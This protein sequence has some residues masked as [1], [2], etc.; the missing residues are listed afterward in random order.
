MLLSRQTWRAVVPLAVAGIVLLA[1]SLVIAIRDVRFARAEAESELVALAEAASAAVV[2]LA[3][4]HLHEYTGNLL[5]HPAVGMV[6]VYSEDRGQTA[7]SREPGDTAPPVVD[8]WIARIVPALREPLV[9]CRATAGIT[10]CVESDMSHYRARVAALIVPHAVLLGATTLLLLVTTILA[11]GSSRNDVRAITTVLQSASDASNYALRAPET[12]GEVAELARAANKLLEQMQ[13]RDVILRRRT[14][15]L[16]GANSELEAFSYSVSHDLRAPLASMNGFSQALREE[17]GEVLDETGREYLSW[18]ESA[19]QQ[20]NSLIQGLLQMSRVSRAEIK[21]A[22]VDVSR[23]AASL[24]DLLRQK[25]PARHVEFRIEPEMT[26]SADEGLLHAVLENLMSNA[27]KFTGKV[28][29]AVI[30]VGT[31]VEQGR[32]AYFV[33][34]N[35][36]GFDSTKAAKMFTPFQRLHT[37]SDFEGTGIGLSTVKR[38]VE[39]HG[40]AIWAEGN[41]GKGAA[42]FF[43]LGESAGAEAKNET[44]ELI[45]V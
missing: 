12:K 6:T 44:P 40:G 19:V 23:M 42:F 5:S 38:I 41:P 3:P 11:R 31:T 32:K 26:A 4:E 35:G 7:R 17:Y 30:T 36:A 8:S 16:E 9:G 29:N 13:Q 18:I 27:F 15:E 1:A 43:T 14:T 21:R 10:V 33:R 25:D 45:G 20:M 34:D 2:F 39:R 37:A 24:A 28:T 22:S